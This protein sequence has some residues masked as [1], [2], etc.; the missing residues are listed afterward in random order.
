M[1]DPA[2]DQDKAE[3]AI[4]AAVDA[5][6]LSFDLR[7]AE[8]VLV[9]LNE[10]DVTLCDEVALI[11][12]RQRAKVADALIADLR[13]SSRGTSPSRHLSGDECAR[14]LLFRHGLQ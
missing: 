8:D 14:I 3:A 6:G 4:V 13:A 1:T 5:T 7:F 2:L 11:A 10:Q 9:G 12:L